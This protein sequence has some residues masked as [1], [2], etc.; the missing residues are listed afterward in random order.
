MAQ[1]EAKRRW[2]LWRIIALASLSAAVMGGGI[3]M[4]VMS[5]TRPVVTASESFMTALKDGDFQSAYD[6][7]TPD[8]RRDLGSPER[9]GAM[10]VPHRPASWSWWSRRI[11]NGT[12]SVSGTLVYGGGQEGD[13]FISLLPDGD[14]WRIAG[15]R[16]SP[17][18]AR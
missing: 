9:L 8:L 4:L 14:G 15:F 11:R 17:Q 16:M 12:G 2:R 1:A 3:V 7:A 18:T 6:M 5:L 13:V 10:F